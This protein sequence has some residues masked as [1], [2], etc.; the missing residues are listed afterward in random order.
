MKHI[1]FQ[2]LF[3]NKKQEKL[4]LVLMLTTLLDFLF[5][6][7][8]MNYIGF[9]LSEIDSLWEI[10]NVR[11]TTY[12]FLIWNLFLAWVPYVLSL[13]LPHIKNKWLVMPTLALWLVFIPNAPYIVTDLLHVGYHPPVP[14]W[15]DTM[16]LFSFAWTGLLL[17][18][19]SLIDVQRFLK[20]TIGKTKAEWLIWPVIGL[21]AYGVYMG[22]Y[23]RWNTWDILKSPFQ[24]FEETVAVLLHPMAYLGTLGLAV[25]MAGVMGVGFMTMRVLVSEK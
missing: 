23:Q 10:K 25:V 20:K 22:R 9:D 8:R 17:G 24:V 14:V 21:C 16:L 12:L 1:P 18:F 19:L 11:G 5:V 7:V 6:G 4:F 3:V 13:F 15:Y 2:K